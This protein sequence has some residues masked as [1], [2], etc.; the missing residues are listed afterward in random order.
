LLFYN[1]PLELFWKKK[2]G[3]RCCSAMKQVKG[4]EA[5]VDPAKAQG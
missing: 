4:V 1:S 5:S 2:K 3:K